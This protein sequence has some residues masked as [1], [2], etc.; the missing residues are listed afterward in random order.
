MPTSQK[1]GPSDSP[2]DPQAK[3]TAEEVAE[4]YKRRRAQCSVELLA[5]GASSLRRVDFR[6]E[7]HTVGTLAIAELTMQQL[8]PDRLFLIA[9]ALAGDALLSFVMNPARER[10]IA[11]SQ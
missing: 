3:G 1:R 7:C 8:D 6:T 10:S 2:C 4:V 5:P 9:F 11:S